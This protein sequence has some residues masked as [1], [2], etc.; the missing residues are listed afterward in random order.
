[1]QTRLLPFS[2]LNAVR[3][4][5][6]EAVSENATVPPAATAP[7]PAVPVEEREPASARI[8]RA[9]KLL[10]DLL[11]EDD[12]GSI[13]LI[14]QASEGLNRILLELDQVA[15]VQRLFELWIQDAP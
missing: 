4:V 15:G 7:I 2:S 3:I 11:L 13:S 6:K 12:L 14:G 1:M 8:R 9:S 5:E 10:E